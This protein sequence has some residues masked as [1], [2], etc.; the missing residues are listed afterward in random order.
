MLKER[1]DS[2][3]A[4]CG[5]R[6]EGGD[7]RH[8]DRQADCFAGCSQGADGSLHRMPALPYAGWRARRAMRRL[9]MLFA[10]KGRADY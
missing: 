1:G 6:D 8:R 3:R 5:C 4:S 2:G 9:R 7:W 10:S